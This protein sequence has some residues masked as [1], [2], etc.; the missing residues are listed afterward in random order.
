MVSGVFG[1]LLMDVEAPEVPATVAMALP[2]VRVTSPLVFNPRLRTA[3]TPLA[4]WDTVPA[5]VTA[6]SPRAVPVPT[7][8][9]KATAPDPAW[10][11]RLWLLA[12]PVPL[13]V[14]AN[15][16][17]PPDVARVVTLPGAPRVT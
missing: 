15:D 6:R 3:S 7:V 13:R 1:A 8:G 17:L 5:L 16:R 4:G 12:A 9:P 10:T 2:P 14:E 11:T